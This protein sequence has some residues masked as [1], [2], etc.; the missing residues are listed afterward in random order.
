MKITESGKEARRRGQRVVRHSFTVFAIVVKK[1]LTSTYDLK[2]RVLGVT[3]SRALGGDRDSCRIIGEK[4]RG[5]NDRDKEYR[6]EH[7]TMKGHFAI[8]RASAGIIVEINISVTNDR[9][10]V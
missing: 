10:S 1:R 6:R 3:P 7:A 8:L 5:Y 9:K 4:I 2:I